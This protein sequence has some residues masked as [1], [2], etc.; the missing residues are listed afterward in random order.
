MIN[1][2]IKK[3]DID[4]TILVTYNKIKDEK[5]YKNIITMIDETVKFSEIEKSVVEFGKK[6]N[7]HKFT[8]YLTVLISA[9]D[10]MKKRYDEKNI[11]E[12]IFWD[13]VEDFTYKIKECKEIYGVF[14]IEPFTWYDGF[15]NLRTFK[16][17]RLEFCRM[18]YYT[19]GEYVIAVH[20]PSCGPLKYEDV[21]DSYKRAYNFFDKTHGDFMAF[22]CGSWLLN[23]N[24]MG[25]V[26][27]E[28]SNIYNFAKDYNIFHIKN[29]EIFHDAWRIFGVAYNGN[30][31]SL[32]QNTSMQKAFVKY[33][34]EG[35][36]PGSG[37]GAFMFDG[38][39]VHKDRAD[40]IK[41][42]FVK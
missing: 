28:G 24:Y 8:L 30:P 15:F 31:S 9:L 42:L 6:V 19:E 17:G 32:P 37:V 40:V 4:D 20:I 39:N 14:G 21:I 38:E 3:F 33:L 18:H 34:E 29:D 10:I 12:E 11:S 26:F 27:K 7:I 5:E 36:I 2:F 35:K 1:E 16:L 25:L 22:S 41:Y 23:P 13:S